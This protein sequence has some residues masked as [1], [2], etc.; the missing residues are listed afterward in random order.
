MIPEMQLFIIIVFFLVFICL[1][2]EYIKKRNAISN[3]RKKRQICE[4][5]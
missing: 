5:F 2:L 4:S 1:L 3:E